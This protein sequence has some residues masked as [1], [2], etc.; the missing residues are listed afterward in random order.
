MILFRFYS[1]RCQIYTFRGFS[2]SYLL[3][4]A[5]EVV[6][7][8]SRDSPRP[9]S[10]AAPSSSTPPSNSSDGGSSRSVI[11]VIFVIFAPKGVGDGVSGGTCSLR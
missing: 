11:I 10:S 3:V 1:A 9:S 8:S 7:L 6:C 5:F 4:K 2:D